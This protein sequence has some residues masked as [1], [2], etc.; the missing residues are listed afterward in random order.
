MTAGIILAQTETPSPTPDPNLPTPTIRPVD[1]ACDLDTLRQ[2]QQA[3]AA[4]LATFDAEAESN[5]GLALDNLFK[6]G[7]AYQELALDC[8]YIPAD[9]A[10]RTVGTDVERILNTL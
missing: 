3:L 10:A 1:L 4:Q 9:A 2:Q 8:G 7:A 6:V 5:A